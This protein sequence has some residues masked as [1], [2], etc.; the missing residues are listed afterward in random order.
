MVIAA[1]LLFHNHCDDKAVY[2][3]KI[4]L[5]LAGILF[6]VLL[7]GPVLMAFSDTIQFGQ[8]WR[9]ANRESAGIAPDAL[10]HPDAIIQVYS[11][12]AFNWRGMFAVHTWI[13][14]KPRAA[15][16]YTVYHVVGWNL[17]R[18]LPVVVAQ[19]DVPDRNWYGYTPEIMVDIRGPG[20]EPIIAA[21]DQA[22]RDY[23]YTHQ[24]TL[25]PGPNSN[26]FTA[27]I[28]RQ[29]PALQLDLP[30]TAIGKDYLVNNKFISTTPSGTGFQFSLYGLFGFL[31]SKQE[32]I[33]V[34]FLTL[35]IGIDPFDL[36]L[37]LPGMG[38]TG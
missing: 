36:K 24:Y 31:F 5:I 12:R 6:T 10:R 7:T 25:W 22:V 1:R 19:T 32:G 3:M 35:S 29:V 37:R 14:A 8:D 28:G 15:R 26:T 9:S 4:S 13:A 16:Q 2:L 27:Y 20:A 33:E 34:N 38:L 18:N 30:P 21:V 17:R 11:A 23:P